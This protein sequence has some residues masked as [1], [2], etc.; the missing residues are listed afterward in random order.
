MR[1]PSCA[2]LEQVPLRSKKNEEVCNGGQPMIDLVDDL[3]NLARALE[4]GLV[5][6]AEAA[7]RLRVLAGRVPTFVVWVEEPATGEPVLCTLST[8]RSEA[9]ALA[10]ARRA[11]GTGIPAGACFRTTAAWPG[12]AWQ[13]GG[14]E[15]KQGGG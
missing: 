6:P 11:L 3:N 5:T 9:R 12:I 4:R 14:T 15:G 8:A 10:E 13:R 1:E 7:A 2:R